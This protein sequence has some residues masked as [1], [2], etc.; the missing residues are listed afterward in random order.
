MGVHP[1]NRSRPAQ[2]CK[3]GASKMPDDLKV[4][5]NYLFGRGE[6]TGCK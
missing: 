1:Y 3:K 2:Q 5:A 4:A 6:K